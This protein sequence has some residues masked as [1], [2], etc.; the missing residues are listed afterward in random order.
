MTDPS[1]QSRYVL[2]TFTERTSYGFK[3]L[4]PYTKLFEERSMKEGS[5]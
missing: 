4:S 5:T 2:P 1:Q 3:E